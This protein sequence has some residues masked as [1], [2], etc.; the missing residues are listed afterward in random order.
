MASTIYW[1]KLNL[2]VTVSREEEIE[3]K[4]P[5]RVSSTLWSLSYPNDWQI[6]GTINLVISGKMSIW[7]GGNNWEGSTF[8]LDDL[9]KILILSVG[10]REQNLTISVSSFNGMFV[11]YYR[12]P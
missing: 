9:S 1:V 4:K 2:G 7:K 12:N 11:S 3:D 6:I 8:F 5:N 10:L